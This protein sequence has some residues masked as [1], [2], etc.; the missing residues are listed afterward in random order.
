MHEDTAWGLRPD[1]VT[2]RRVRNDE[3]GRREREYKNRSVIP[4]NSTSDMA[5]HG[6]DDEGKVKAYKGYV[7]GSNFCMDIVCNDKGKWEGEIVSTYQAYQIIRQHGRDKGLAMLRSRSTSISGKPL[8]MRLQN[9]DI[10][11]MMVGE[12]W[13]L[14][15]LVATNSANGQMTLAEINEANVDT[16]NRNKE[17]IFAYTTKYAG[18]LQK[19]KARRVTISPIGE[20]TD[21]GFKE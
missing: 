12:R 3:T 16:R 5:R 4:F 8:V 13:C 9:G 1:G 15:R 18:S 20:V 19:S 11:K 10:V 14:M 2:T 17:D 7:G 21:H 6:L